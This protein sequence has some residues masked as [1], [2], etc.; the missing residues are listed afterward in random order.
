MIARFWKGYCTADNAR[1]YEFNA[2]GRRPT[3]L[4]GVVARERQDV[5]AS[6]GANYTSVTFTLFV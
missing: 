5:P 2:A 6:I 4:P 1:A 3:T